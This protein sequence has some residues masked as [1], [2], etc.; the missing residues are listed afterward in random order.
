MNWQ[1]VYD[2]GSQETQQF[3]P[4]VYV[5][6]GLL[7]LA[8]GLQLWARRRGQKSFMAIV[9]AI[10]AALA[11]GLGYG[12]GVWDQQRLAARL[13]SGNVLQVQG[14]VSAHQQ[15]RQDVGS[16][17]NSSAR[18]YTN[19]ETIT[20]GGVAFIWSPGE[21]QAAFSNAQ[22]PPLALKDGLTLRVSYVE[23]VPGKAHER[24][25]LRLEVQGAGAALK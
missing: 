4:F 11:G 22:T 16:S 19:F 5:G 10:A 18:R 13:R 3:L 6:L 2:I 25:I 8:L 17:S 14:A 1:L 7:A 24:R 21:L 15:W 9:T 12:L 23:D 20:V